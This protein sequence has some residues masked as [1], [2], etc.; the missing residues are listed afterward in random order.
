MQMEKHL[1][2][3]ITICLGLCFIWIAFPAAFAADSVTCESEYGS[4]TL[5]ENGKSYECSDGSMGNGGSSNTNI[6]TEEEC[7]RLLAL[8]CGGP[9]CDGTLQ[10][11]TAN[12]LGI[13]YD[14]GGAYRCFCQ[15]GSSTICTELSADEMRAFEALEFL[16]EFCDAI[17]PDETCL[18]E[19]GAC[20]L[21]PS[22]ILCNCLSGGVEGSSNFDD[23]SLIPD[24]LEGKNCTEVID[25]FCSYQDPQDC[26]GQALD[27]CHDYFKWVIECQG[28]GNNDW[29]PIDECCG[30]HQSESEWKAYQ[31]CLTGESCEAAEDACKQLK[32][33]PVEDPNDGD[34]SG[35]EPDG[36]DPTDGNDSE[37]TA[38]GNLAD[39]DAT[40]DENEG[41]DPSG[42]KAD[43]EDSCSSTGGS[44]SVLWLVLM[45]LVLHRRRGL[46]ST[47]F[48]QIE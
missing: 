46:A 11:S 18:N 7:L 3:T 30:I 17:E 26:S 38:D 32:P 8:N 29:L 43:D 36:D 2:T 28:M 34:G 44:S 23:A 42:L 47:L 16:A 39:G 5:R 13:C 40:G 48:C 22:G 41:D 27:S 25:H 15:D 1:K 14:Y 24:F 33:A 20:D 6:L 45:L 4:M 35:A 9:S 19:N 10:S 37:G 12:E 21:Y 31:K